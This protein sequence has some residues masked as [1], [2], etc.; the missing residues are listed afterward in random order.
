MYKEH[1]MQFPVLVLKCLILSDSEL[2]ENGIFSIVCFSLFQFSDHKVRSDMNSAKILELRM[3]L[4]LV[5]P[6]L[7]FIL[8]HL[9]NAG[10]NQLVF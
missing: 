7:V 6:L 8:F 2:G 3:N 4:D 10:N 9:I 1:I 5:L